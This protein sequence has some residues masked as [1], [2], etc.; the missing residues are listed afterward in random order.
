[1]FL[2][3]VNKRR[4]YHGINFVIAHDG[5]SLHDLVSYNFKVAPPKVVS[6]NFELLSKT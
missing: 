4:P 5:F 6:F 1:M 2:F 3:Q